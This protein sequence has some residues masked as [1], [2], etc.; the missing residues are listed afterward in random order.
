MPRYLLS[1]IMAADRI[2]LN[3]LADTLAE[4]R[5]EYDSDEED[6]IV[7]GLKRVKNVLNDIEMDQKTIKYIAKLSNGD[8]RFAYNLVEFSYYGFNHKVTID[9]IKEVNNILY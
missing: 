3:K 9:N 6:D 7:K 4:I 1:L 5:D 8:I 2:V